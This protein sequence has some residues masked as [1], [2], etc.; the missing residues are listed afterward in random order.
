[1]RPTEPRPRQSWFSQDA[2]NCR[3]YFPQPTAADTV[4]AIPLT[5]TVARA[6]KLTGMAVSV[7]AG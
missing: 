3:T 4:R 6:Q 2:T 7:S 1:M 5:E